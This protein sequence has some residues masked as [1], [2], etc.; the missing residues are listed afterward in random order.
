MVDNGRG[1]YGETP[2]SQI[3]SSN[4]VRGLPGDS[5]NTF[6]KMA[7]KPSQAITA[8]RRGNYKTTRPGVGKPGA[9]EDE[10]DQHTSSHASVH[11]QASSSQD[12]P[13]NKYVKS[14]HIDKG[15]QKPLR[16]S[17]SG[18]EEH[19][20]GGRRDQ[21]QE[22]TPTRTNSPSQQKFSTGIKDG[23]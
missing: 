3:F 7:K 5:P 11:A 12:P 18:P 1:R 14:K 15:C 21:K 6:N 17:N 23:R 8:K 16:R 10:R 9:R 20:K 22:P 2:P 19:H 4:A 13:F